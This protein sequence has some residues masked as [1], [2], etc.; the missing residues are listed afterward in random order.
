MYSSKQ[1][2][3]ALKKARTSLDRVI[4]MVEDNKYCIDIIQQ[5]LA[6]IGLLKSVN[7]KLLESHL[8]SCFVTAVKSDDKEKLNEMISEI[9]NIVKTAQNK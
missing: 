9:S 4:N 3:I 5:N 2:L 7:T 6:V 8:S 1:K